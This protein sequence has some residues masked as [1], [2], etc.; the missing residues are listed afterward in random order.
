MT[1]RCSV[2]RMP[3]AAQRASI[4][5]C[6][7]GGGRFQVPV[8]VCLPEQVGVFCHRAGCY[9]KSRRI[10]RAFNCSPAGLLIVAFAA[11]DHHQIRP[12][13][14]AAAPAGY[15][16][17]PREILCARR[18]RRG[19]RDGSAAA[20]AT[21]PRPRCA[22]STAIERISASSAPMRDDRKADCL[23]AEP[24]PVHERVALAA[25]CPRTRLRPSRGERTRRAVAPAARRRA[26]RPARRRPCRRATIPTS[27]L[28]M[29]LRLVLRA[30][31][32]RPALRRA[33]SDRTA[34]PAWLR[35]WPRRRA[36]R[37]SRYRAR[38]ARRPQRVADASFGQR[39]A[40]ILR[41]CRPDAAHRSCEA[42]MRF[43]DRRDARRRTSGLPSPADD[44]EIDV[45][46]PR[47]D[48]GD[49]RRRAALADDGGGIGRQRASARPP[50]CSPQAQGRAPPKCRRA[51]PVKLPGP[52]VTAMRSSVVEGK[53]GPLASRA[54]SAASAL[55]HGRASCSSDSC[56]ISSALSVSSTA[57]AQAFQ[58]G[59][60]GED[61]ACGR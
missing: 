34:A 35:D 42:A 11:P 22:W 56:A 14:R 38:A 31:A 48:R 8:I 60:D 27:H 20:C 15:F 24:Q 6:L 55:R 53:T 4:P 45:I 12:D 58:R 23:A 57:A 44:L 50:A 21:D 49:H 39:S 59:I 7:G 19:G 25:A 61:R 33:P 40:R 3:V 10:R 43:V 46:V 29:R 54:R 26:W 52:M 32:V 30:A 28:I 5:V 51:S 16:P 13:H 47:I 17:R 1:R 41:H 36:R 9:D 18:A 37:P 2:M